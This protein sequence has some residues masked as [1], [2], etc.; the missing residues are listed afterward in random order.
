L[1]LSAKREPF[2]HLRGGAGAAVILVPGLGGRTDFFS[3]QIPLLAE[4]WTVVTWDQRG[5]GARA[6]EPPCH[7]PAELAADVATILDDLD[8][9]PAALVG[10]SMGAGICQHFALDGAAR[11]EGMVLSSAWATPKDE[12]RALITK[13]RQILESE[14]PAAYLAASARMSLPESAGTSIDAAALAERAATLDV[15]EELARLDALHAHDL[16]A[17]VSEI[18]LPVELL[19]AADD[20]LTPPD[21]SKDL[22]ERLPQSRL[23]ILDHGGHMAPQANAG[24][25]SAALIRSLARLL[26]PTH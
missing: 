26:P 24:E 21:M 9:Q 13:R 19:A 5:V 15:D 10:H 1:E 17:R 4:H 7:R 3:A 14:G 8:S 11:L 22:A 12:F 25:Y 16:S 2:A 23:T 20:R 6:N 18:E